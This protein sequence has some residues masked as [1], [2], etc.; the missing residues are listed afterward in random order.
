MPLMLAKRLKMD[1]EEVHEI[2]KNA[3]GNNWVLSTYTPVSNLTDGVPSNNKYRPGFSA[4][5]M[6]KD[7]KLANI[8]AKS[9]SASTP[10]GK[11]ALEIFSEF[12][13]EGDYETD[14]SGISKKIGGDECD[15]PFDSKGKD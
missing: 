3:C 6:T 7:L 11:H 9:V 12:C 1:L 10:L 4:S 5:M 8:A 15:Y 14:Y 13:N 2:M